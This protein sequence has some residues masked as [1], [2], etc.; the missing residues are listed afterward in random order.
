[1]SRCKEPSSA[2]ISFARQ[3]LCLIIIIIIIIFN[4]KG[5]CDKYLLIYVDVEGCPN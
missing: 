2:R 3:T 4:Y 5:I 1:M